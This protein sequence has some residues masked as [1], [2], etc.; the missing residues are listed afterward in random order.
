MAYNSSKT[1][2]KSLKKSDRVSRRTKNWIKSNFVLDLKPN[3]GSTHRRTQN[4]MG[5]VRYFFWRVSYERDSRRRKRYRNIEKRSVRGSPRFDPE[6]TFGKLWTSHECKGS[7]NHLRRKYSG[8][9]RSFETFDRRVSL[10]YARASVRRTGPK[11]RSADKLNDN[12][13]CLFSRL[14]SLSGDRVRVVS[15]ARQKSYAY[16]K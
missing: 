11:R 10:V 13:N 7:A 2:R 8:V 15:S 1:K 6:P 16:I 14:F 4:G 5:F 12:G 3:V 9:R